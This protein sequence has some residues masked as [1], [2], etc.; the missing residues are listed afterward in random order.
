MG[1]RA[2]PQGTA[3]VASVGLTEP[4][5]AG[6]APG[7]GLLVGLWS[8]VDL[9]HPAVGVDAVPPAAHQQTLRGVGEVS[10]PEYL[11]VESGHHLGLR[12]VVLA[13]GQRNVE[14]PVGTDPPIGGFAALVRG[15][16]P[17]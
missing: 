17:A 11:L 13:L 16:A 5:A 10:I 2:P 7:Q 9:A 15:D 12:L 14:L 8:N 4:V 6:L 3:T 1:L